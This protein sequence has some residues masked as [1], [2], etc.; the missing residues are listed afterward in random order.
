MI[1]DFHNTPI[2]NMKK[3]VPNLFD[4]KSMGFTK[5]K[6]KKIHHVLEFNKLPWL[7]QFDELNTQKKNR[8]RKHSGKDRKALYKLMK[9]AMYGRT[10]ENL[11][12]RIGAKLVSN[13]KDC[14]KW[15]SKPSYMSQEKHLA[16]I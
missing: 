12:N 6:T 16:M 14:L 4:K 15:T 7:K 3:L 8:C 2:G 13:E 1:A 10:M 9:N 11:R 5:N